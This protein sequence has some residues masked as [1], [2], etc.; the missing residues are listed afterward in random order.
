MF[1]IVSFPIFFKIFFEIYFVPWRA[2]SPDPNES[3]Q[4]NKNLEFCLLTRSYNKHRFLSAAPQK[5]TKK[6][7]LSGNFPLQRIF[8]SQYSG[9]FH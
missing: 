9:V 2:P 6:E 5:K 3:L 8:F 7:K 4:P 1:S